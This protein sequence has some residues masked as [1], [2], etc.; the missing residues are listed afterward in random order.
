MK[1]GITGHQ[2][3]GPDE[4]VERVARTMRTVVQGYRVSEGFTCLAR[5][6]DQ[7]YTDILRQLGLPFVVVIPCENYASVFVSAI[8]RKRFERLLGL[9]SR[10]VLLPFPEPSETAF[11]E[12]GKR[13]VDLSEAVIA[14]WD[15]KPARGL[16]G[17]G[18]I[19][20]Y[21]LSKGRKVMQIDPVSGGVTEL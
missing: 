12:A 6:A 4:N 3:L 19:V 8:D 16:G 14:A 13:V 7:L 18:D 17:T 10:T 11:Y 15:G 21:A 20:R 1:T 2:D 9:A 5:G